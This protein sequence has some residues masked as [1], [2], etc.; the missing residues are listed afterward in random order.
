MANGN[1]GIGGFLPFPTFG[2]EKSGGITPV[3]L[4]PMSPNFPTPRAINRRTPEPEFKETIAP[5]LPFATEG[6]LGLIRG[7]DAP[8]TTADREDY[9]KEDILY[10]E[11]RDPTAPFTKLQQA[12]LDAYDIY[13][14]PDEGGADWGSIIANLAVGSQ[15]GRGAGDY[16]TTALALN[17]AGKTKGA[18]TET[19]RA[20][21]I[22]AKMKPD[23]IFKSFQDT[24][25]KS[26]DAD[27]KRTGYFD[28]NTG[29]SYI[30]SDDKSGFTN[31]RDH[32]GKWIP[33]ADVVTKET[34]VDKDYAALSKFDEAFSNRET[35]LIGTM[36]VGNKTIEQMD[37]AL[38]DPGA[39]PL[40]VISSLA[41][42]YNDISQNVQQL[43][44]LFGGDI[45]DGFADL[46]DVANNISGSYGRSGN[47]QAAKALQIAL[48]SGNDDQIA[49]AIKNFTKNSDLGSYQSGFQQTL[50][51]LSYANVRTQGTLLQLAYMAAAANGQS[52]RT[53]SDKDLAFHLQMIGKGASQSPGVIRKNLL[54]FVDTIGESITNEIGAVFGPARANRY[55]LTN[56]KNSTIFSTYWKNGGREDKTDFTK[57]EEYMYGEDGGPSPNLR[58][59][60]ERFSYL[61][62][63]N[64]WYSHEGREGTFSQTGTAVT[65][66]QSQNRFI[67]DLKKI[68][69]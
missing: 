45:L 18:A 51:E 33:I 42:I 47:G 44:A 6:L 7:E 30:I 59:F 16:A 17:K 28:K 37:K 19:A 32:V 68:I 2:G 46:D 34:E 25:A 31:V 49:A 64:L 12:K 15:M 57:P 23:L 53:L 55:D 69:Q 29:E 38:L 52:G 40:T 9:I 8:P 39:N 61:P 62:A 65:P 48:Q 14:E 10:G 24:D 22:K 3:Q 66:G 50:D 11:E 58:T 20:E 21:F 4:S 43:G 60:R 5:L 27:D 35:A 41:N 26:R 54:A 56:D 13:G 63:V 1:Q 67:T 36:T